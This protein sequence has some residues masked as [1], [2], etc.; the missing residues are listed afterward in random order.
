VAPRE[1]ASRN[2]LSPPLTLPAAMPLLEIPFHEI[3]NFNAKIILIGEQIRLETDMSSP[4]LQ[5]V[6]KFK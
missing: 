3:R 6:G 1:G 2:L 5:F 4:D